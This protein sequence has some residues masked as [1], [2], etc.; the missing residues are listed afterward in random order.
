MWFPT[1]TP[2]QARARIKSSP[3]PIS[4]GQLNDIT[5]LTL[6]AYQRGGL[7]TGLTRL[8]L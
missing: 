6:P 3:R 8:T 5:V 2:E 1:R 7:A 4:T